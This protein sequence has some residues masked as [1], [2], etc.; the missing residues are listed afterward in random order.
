MISVLKE[1]QE[2]VPMRELLE[3]YGIYPKR[4]T[5]NYTCLFHS[6]DK[7]PSAGI[8][9]D[10]YR[11]RCYA[12]G[13][14]ASIFDVV[15]KLNDCDYKT[16][17]KIIDDEFHLGILGRLTSKE[18]LEI[19]QMRR[20]LE[21]QKFEIKKMKNFEK[22]VLNKICQEL[23]VWEDCEKLTHLTRGEYRRGEW[24]HGDLYFYSL[25]QQRWLNW[26]YETICGFTDKQECEFDYIYG[27]DKKEILEKIRRGEIL[28]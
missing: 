23:R 14:Y 27:N 24:K 19:A 1:M 17:L 5:N 6:P 10:G 2:K 7:H 26:L 21:L 28:I 4:S 22:L 25:K 12:C 9:K 18:K 11:L 16:A 8:T 3:H 20:E 15:C 13:T